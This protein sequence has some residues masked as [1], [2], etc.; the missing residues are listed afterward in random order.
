MD[1]QLQMLV[2]VETDQDMANL[3]GSLMDS[4]TMGLVSACRMFPGYQPRL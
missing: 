3:S 2:E 4:V 1:H